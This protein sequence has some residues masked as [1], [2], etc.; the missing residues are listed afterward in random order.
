MEAC[1]ASAFEP[2]KDVL[3]RDN[4]AGW[5]LLM[6]YDRFSTRAYLLQVIGYPTA[7]IEWI[8]MWHGGTGAFRGGFVQVRVAN[9]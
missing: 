8:E 9:I 7:V 1:F 2:F 5:E 4:K 6:K 3:A